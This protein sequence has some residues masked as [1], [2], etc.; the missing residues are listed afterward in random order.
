[1][2][3]LYFEAP[4]KKLWGVK[5]LLFTLNLEISRCYISVCEINVFR[6]VLH[7]QR[8]YFT[9]FNQSDHCFLVHSTN[10]IIV[11]WCSQPIR[12]LF[13][14]AFN[15]SD[16]CFRVHSSNQIIV[17][18]CIQPIRSLFSGAFNQSDHCFL[19]HSTNQIIVSGAVVAGIAVVALT[20]FLRLGHLYQ[21][22]EVVETEVA[23]NK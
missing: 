15:Q 10:R 2:K 17:F 13:S 6:C 20:A 23:L 18:W 9:S 19:V 16:H 3:L 4:L 8:D 5:D 14:G 12:S 22:R 7:V 21:N 1:M 11:F